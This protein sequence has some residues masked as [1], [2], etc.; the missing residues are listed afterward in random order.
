MAAGDTDK[1][2]GPPPGAPS[3]GHTHTGAPAHWPAWVRLSQRRQTEVKR[4]LLLAFQV[5]A[6]R[7]RGLLS[8][9]TFLGFSF[10]L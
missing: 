8:E 10:L 9:F 6:S 5:H 2:L 4:A 3:Q 1:V 7:A